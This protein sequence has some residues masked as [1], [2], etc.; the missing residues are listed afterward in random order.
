MFDARMGGRLGST[1]RRDRALGGA[2]AAPPLHTLEWGAFL[3]VTAGAL[4]VMLAEAGMIGNPAYL[5]LGTAI[6][7]GCLIT[8]PWRNNAPTSLLI[9]PLV[10][11]QWRFGEAVAP[12]LFVATIIA[13]FARG[14]HWLATLTAS[15]VD[16][17]VFLIASLAALWV[18]QLGA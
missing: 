17:I 3:L 11:A 5:A 1:V 18:P 12:L 2:A 10:A 14:S 16:L 15:S 6:L 9:I 4:A 8:V 7:V 13:N